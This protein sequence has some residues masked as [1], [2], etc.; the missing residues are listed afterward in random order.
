MIAHIDCD[1]VWLIREGWGDYLDSVY[2]I[3]NMLYLLG[4]WIY[5][6]IVNDLF[7][8]QWSGSYL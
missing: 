4:L 7:A 8:V 3:V 5:V 1:C 6:I 2:L